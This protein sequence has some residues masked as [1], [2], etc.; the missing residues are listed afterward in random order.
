LAMTKTILCFGDS[1]THG[2][3]P[4]VH[5]EDRFSYE[6]RWP[7]VLAGVLGCEWRVIEEGLG[8][9]TTVRDDPVEG[10]HR[11]G[12]TYLLPCLLSHRPID[13]VALMLGTN[14]LKARFNV[15]PWDVAEGIAVLIAVIRAAGCG[16]GGLP[17]GILIVAPPVIEPTTPTYE[18]MFAGACQK[19]RQLA[20]YYMRVANA[21]GTEFFDAGQVATVGKGD[22]VHL[23]REGHAVLGRGIGA[24]VKARWL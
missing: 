14:D 16:R 19:S 10:A 12:R 22:G 3:P 24:T 5:P 15:S 2:F 23:G 18:E 11:N 9:R 1:N 6:E 21:T 13:V 8:G 7:G 17:P 20:K 4:A